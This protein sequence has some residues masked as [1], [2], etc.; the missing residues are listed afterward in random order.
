[1]GL[2][3]LETLVRHAGAGIRSADCLISP[4]L[5]GFSYVRFSQRRELIARG[6]Q[7]TEEKLPLIQAALATDPLADHWP[8]RQGAAVVVSGVG[9]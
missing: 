6:M 2:T 5:A 3:A 9:D 4:D 8:R 7:A 1:M